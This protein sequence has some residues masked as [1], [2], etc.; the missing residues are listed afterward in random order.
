MKRGYR[1]VSEERD[2][3]ELT[4]RYR[5]VEDK[6]YLGDPPPPPA[7]RAGSGC[8]TAL[9]WT[10]AGLLALFALAVI[11]ACGGV[12]VVAASVPSADQLGALRL[13]QS[14]KIYDRNGGM[15]FEIFDPNAASGGRR[16][17]ISPDKI[18][19]VLKQATIATEDP[20]FYS[21]LGVDPVGVARAI[22][23][24]LRYQ[25]AL[26]GGSTITQQLVKNTLLTPELTIE[27]KLR[28]AV[29]AF[30]I[31]QR[32]S[33]D[34]IL[35]DYMNSIYYGNLS[36][37]IEAASMSY[38]KKDVSQLDLAE[39]SL[40]AGLPQAPA[41]YDPCS[42][43]DAALERQQVVLSLMVK[44]G[45]ISEQESTDAA[46]E[47]ETTL[48]SDDFGARCNSGIGIVAP[49]FVEFVRQQLED[50][51]GPEIVYKGGLQ[52][53]TT[54]DPTMQKIAE[55][56]A[57]K[58]IDAIKK[59]N[60]TDA[61]LVAANPQTGEIYAMLGSADFF[62]KSIDGQV[63]VA[64]SPRQ[65]GSSIKPINYVTAL[66]KGWT[67]ATPLLD[68]S[69][70]FPNGSQPPYVPVDYDGKEHGIVTLRTALANSLNIPAVKTLYFVG[71]KEMIATAQKMGITT[72]KD[73]SRYGLALTLGGGEV[74]L[75]ELT[76]AYAVLANQGRQAPLAAV[77]KVVDGQG[78]TL[79][80]IEQNQPAPQQVVDPRH[81]YLITSVLSDNNARSME[82]G[83]NSALKL[84]RP[85]AAKTG[86][87]NDFKDNWTLGYTPE[88]VVGVWV[89]NARNTAMKNVSGI[90]GAAPIWHNV[91]ERI[92]KEDDLLN[93]VVPHEFP[94]P[95][96]LVRATVCNE[97]GLL[98]TDL[99]PP[100]HRHA[101]I[102]LA[103]QAPKDPDN[104]W[105]KIKI[106]KTNNLLAN[107]NCPPDIV[108]ERVFERMPQDAVLPYDQVVKWANDHG[109]PQPPAQQ[110]PCTSQPA[111][112]PTA[113]SVNQV[114]I[115]SPADGE[116]VSGR[117][118][119]GGTADVP[120]F[121]NFVVE[122]GQRN[123]GTG[124][125]GPWFKIGAGSNP[126]VNGVLALVDTQ[127]GPDGPYALRLTVF[128]G[129]GNQF[130]DQVGINII[131]TPESPTPAPTRTPKSTA[132]PNTTATPNPTSPA[133]GGVGPGTYDYRD[134]AIVYAGNWTRT[135]GF[136]RSGQ[137]GA[138]ASLTVSGAQG[139]SITTVAG[140]NRGIAN[141]LVDGN[142]VGTF[143]GYRANQRSLVEGPYAL[144][145]LGQHTIT[146]QVTG[147]KS[148]ASNGTNVTLSN[149][150]VTG[151]ASAMNEAPALPFE[152]GAAVVDERPM[153]ES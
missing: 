78:H 27:R 70:P 88:L 107:D 124:G 145:D 68:V 148:A 95:P 45:Y 31:T 20:S 141:V 127:Q 35:A 23:Y 139:F 109:I 112:L 97:S 98:P 62:D 66:E 38:F 80:D 114:K 49:H 55:E 25:R 17:V 146:I 131:N 102:F 48:H 40:L 30:A 147:G 58:Q 118:K 123:S 134:P 143:D 43:P 63:N 14:T 137:A 106:D 142:V 57:K 76:G 84:S 59:N 34:Q 7:A 29:L 65:P 81:A 105:V 10:G 89:G 133:P 4:R 51:Y 110:S 111:P 96:G 60:V 64:T 8:R 54:L 87:T 126:V 151:G 2:A 99:C 144:P 26:I 41:L 42:S 69:T 75:V 93:R 152:T 94:I 16:T 128:D 18:P 136:A 15:L 125:T 100:D 33:K 86:T 28:E 71:V 116:Q 13:D 19:S 47:T 22:Y 117:V 46:S 121:T 85:A 115:T 138:T 12:A 153:Q 44:A 113:P 104:L 6:A 56:E 140:P 53:Y 72:F 1:A 24:D 32:Y 130:Q 5:E 149:F 52:V 77:R 122:I 50:K 101:E 119:I 91:M 129:S 9:V 3:H 67:L 135:G 92:Y 83:V 74:K 132:T 11:A 150:I 36:Y 37:G 108:E 90:T 73:P 61:A 79:Y 120:G 21:N 82:F 39:A 103:E